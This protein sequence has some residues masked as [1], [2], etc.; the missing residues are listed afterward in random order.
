MK[1]I[2]DYL[3]GYGKMFV[4]HRTDN[5]PKCE[6]FISG[7][8]HGCKSNIE[9]MA[10]RIPQSD[11][12]QLQH[13]ISKSPWDAFAVMNSM[14]EKLHAT[15]TLPS[16]S[17]DLSSSLGLI[18]DE[19]GWEKSGKKSVEVARQYIGQVGKV[20]NGQVGVFAGLTDGIRRLRSQIQSLLSSRW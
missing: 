8:L 18:I 12:H 14:S 1:K 15:L 6:Q 13:F 20:S 9:R 3:K 2:S 10:E 19:S 7:L 4:C 11:Y 5:L 17:R 16:E